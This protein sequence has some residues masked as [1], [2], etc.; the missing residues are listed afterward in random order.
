[1]QILAIIAL[2]AA[3][4]MTGAFIPMVDSIKHASGPDAAGVGIGIF[5]L[6]ILR[7]AALIA[8]LL[9]LVGAGKMDGLVASR[10]WQ[11]VIVVGGVLVMELVSCGM[12]FC[13]IDNETSKP[14]LTV[15]AVLATLL[16]ALVM[17]AG[18]VAAFGVGGVRL[19]YL[20]GMGLSV[21]A[22][23]GAYV[24]NDALTAEHRAER[25]KEIE[26]TKRRSA[27]MSLL[28]ENAGVVELLA[29]TTANDPWEVRSEALDRMAKI[30]GCAGQLIGMLGGERKLGALF[31]LYEQRG[32]LPAEA[33]EPSWRAAGELA[34]EFSARL[35]NGSALTHNEMIMLSRPVRS[36][37]EQGGNEARVQHVD[38]MVAVRDLLRRA[39]KKRIFLDDPEVLFPYIMPGR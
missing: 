35:D 5:L 11:T 1:M 18:F 25:A 14:F 21:T 36:L 17:G 3:V 6:S 39:A 12:H 19:L 8:G 29:F 34:R 38:D 22:G 15:F 27:E 32:D 7:G 23:L 33:R 24:F 2:V 10:G 20:A 31:S 16:P 13:S 30:D 37:A 9:I 4:V 26:I 28:P